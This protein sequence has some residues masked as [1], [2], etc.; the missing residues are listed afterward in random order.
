MKSNWKEYLINTR[1]TRIKK[2]KKKNQ[3]YLER[4]PL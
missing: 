1:L 3:I 4:I 2:T